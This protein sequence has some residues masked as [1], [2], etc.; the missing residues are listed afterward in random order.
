[1]L[2]L[3][4]S[5]P[6]RTHLLPPTQHR[7]HRHRCSH[8]RSPPIII[9]AYPRM[10]WHMTWQV[11]V[12]ATDGLGRGERRRGECEQRLV[13]SR[14]RERVAA[15]GH[16]LGVLHTLPVDARRTQGMPWTRLQLSRSRAG[17]ETSARGTTWT[18]TRLS[19]AAAAITQISTVCFGAVIHHS[20]RSDIVETRESSSTLGDCRVKSK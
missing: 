2:Q 4:S 18:A 8:S 13:L 16:E 10:T 14:L 19:V 17:T 7:R 20:R 1:M 3:G 12:D 9:K 6:N 11:H 15:D 5:S